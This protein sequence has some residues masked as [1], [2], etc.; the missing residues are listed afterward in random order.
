M[1]PINLERAGSG[2]LLV[3]DQLAE[4]LALVLRGGGLGKVDRRQAVLHQ[5]ESEF[6]VISPGEVGS[7]AADRKES[8]AGKREVPAIAVRTAGD[9]SGHRE[10]AVMT[11]PRCRKVRQVPIG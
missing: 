9:R 3:A 2:E 8:G 5:P 6:H 4:S 10:P 1:S 11:L 7:E